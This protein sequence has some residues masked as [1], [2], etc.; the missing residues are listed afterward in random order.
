MRKL[1][2]FLMVIAF[3]VVNISTTAHAGCPDHVDCHETQLVESIASSSHNENN[4]QHGPCNFCA[5]TSHGHSQMILAPIKTEYVLS[6]TNILRSLKDFSYF[7][8]YYYPPTEP[9]KA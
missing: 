9:P 4:E 2:S 3:L 5:C 1:P 7:S 8:Q 6:S